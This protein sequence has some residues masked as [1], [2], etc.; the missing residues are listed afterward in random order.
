MIEKQRK[1]LN[2]LVS[3]HFGQ[4]GETLTAPITKED[5]LIAGKI[6]LYTG[7]LFGLTSLASFIFSAKKAYADQ[8]TN[9]QGHIILEMNM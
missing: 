1:Y 5:V 7:V 8:T 4:V 6:T 2:D 9:H 3:T